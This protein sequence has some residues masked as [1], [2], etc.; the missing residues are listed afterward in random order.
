MSLLKTLAGF[1]GPSDSVPSSGGWW[2]N[3]L[4]GKTDAGIYVSERLALSL[5]VVYACVSLVADSLA[6]LPAVVEKQT[7]DAK[8]RLVREPQ[9]GHRV[10]NLLNK[11]PNKN[12]TPFSYRQTSMAHALMWGNGYSDLRLNN[13]GE[14]IDLLPLLPYA[15]TPYFPDPTEEYPTVWYRSTLNG[16]HV[17]ERP[18][19]Q[20]L[21]IRGLSMDGL[22]GLSPLATARNAVG[23]GLAMEKYGNKF[24][25]NDARSG[26]FLEHPGQLGEQAHR[27]L[28]ESFLAQNTGLEN[29]HQVKILE[30]GMKFTA[31]SI[32]PE[33]AQFL[34]SRDFQI[35]EIARLYRVPLILLQSMAKSTT[36]GSGIEQILL[37]FVRWTLQ[38]WITQ[39]EQEATLKLLTE[40]ERAAG[41]VVRLDVSVLLRADSVARAAWYKAMSDIAALVPNEVRAEEGMNPVEWG[42]EPRPPSAAANTLPD[43]KG[44]GSV[45][46][47]GDPAADADEEEEEEEEATT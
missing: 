31:N 9:R 1:F 47:G 32:P 34:G 12:M 19:D 13:R 42:D 17:I 16:G 41:L 8:G 30:E 38:P 25:A 10:S 18:T 33:D 2:F 46:K 20:V 27:N 26:G 35:A 29:A 39:F 28:R 22:V 3:Y 21:H 14:V 44:D 24:F 15:T 7:T 37:G 43:V 45:V 40:A 4:G 11:R 6:M 36:W 5:P 23:W